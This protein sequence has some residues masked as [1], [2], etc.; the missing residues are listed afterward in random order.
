MNRTDR[1]RQ[2]KVD[3]KQLAHGVDP[4]SSDPAL[5]AAMARQMLRLFET[6][7]SEKN[8]DPAVK[9]FHAKVEATLKGSTIPVA[10]GKGCAHC[11]HSWVSVIAPEAL[12][13]AKQIR[14]KEGGDFVEKVK[15]A[16]RITGDL[17]SAARTRLAAPCPLL[18]ADLCS[19]YQW[20]PAVCR[21][22]AS[23]S[24]TACQR[25]LRLLAP[26]TIPTPARNVRGRV[27]YEIAASIALVEAGLPHRYYEFNAALMRALER[28]DAEAAWLAGED[29]FAGVRQDPTDTAATP[30]AQ[31]IRRYAFR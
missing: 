19:V 10:C 22:A 29:V 31:A 5:I 16:Y 25:V 27:A 26:E 28:D 18:A 9:F 7:K 8:I 2:A 11:C 12:F 6:A 1:K 15:A 3:E 23:V 4:E 20:R 13:V 17:D 14:K 24:A 21:F 30:N